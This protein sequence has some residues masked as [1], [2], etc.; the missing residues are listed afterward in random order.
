MPL[1]THNKR[2]WEYNQGAG[3]AGTAASTSATGTS[4]TNP[5]IWL[6]VQEEPQ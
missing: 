4:K 1:Q 5:E 2:F 3:M 6:Q